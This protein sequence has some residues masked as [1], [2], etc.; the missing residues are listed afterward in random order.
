MRSIIEA[1]VDGLMSIGEGMASCFGLFPRP[2]KVK[3]VKQMTVEEAFEEDARNLR[4][5]AKRVE[6]DFEKVS[7][8]YWEDGYDR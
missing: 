5:D 2:P 6:R 7:R 1:L 8:D 3:R 4:E